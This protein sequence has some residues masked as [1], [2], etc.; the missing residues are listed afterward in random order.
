MPL[1]GACQVCVRAHLAAAFTRGP[2]PVCYGIVVA[3]RFY[4]ADSEVRPA[5]RRNKLLARSVSRCLRVF[6]SSLR[7]CSYRVFVLSALCIFIFIF[8][9]YSPPVLNI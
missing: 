5:V 3:Y 1:P 9:F 2:A 6:Q 8:Y 7:S 4:E